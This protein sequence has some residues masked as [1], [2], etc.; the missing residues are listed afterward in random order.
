[1]PN[2]M[3]GAQRIICWKEFV[4]FLHKGP[5]IR[6]QVVRLGDKVLYLMSW[7]LLLFGW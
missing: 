7:F 2:D 1:M 4:I 5:G 6:I 3:Y